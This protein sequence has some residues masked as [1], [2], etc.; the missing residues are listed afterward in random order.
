MQ[1][2]TMPSRCVAVAV[3]YSVAEAAVVDTDAQCC[4]MLFADVDE[5]YKAFLQLVELGGIFLVSIFVFYKPACR[6]YVIAG[7]YAHALN[8]GGCHVG[9]VGVEVH[10]GH[11]RRGIAVG[12]DAGLYVSEVFS[13]NGALRCQPDELSAGFY[14]ALRLSDAGISVAC[15]GGSHRLH[16]HRT[17]AAYYRAACAD[18]CCLPTAVIENIHHAVSYI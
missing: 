11:Q 7:V 16:P 14:D 5:L 1:L 13:L 8:D 10:V 12:H 3:A 15:V 2:S 18:R 9:H 6:V 4:V 17:V